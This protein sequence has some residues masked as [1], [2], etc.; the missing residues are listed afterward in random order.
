MASDC[1][2]EC[3]TFSIHQLAILGMEIHICVPKIDRNRMVFG[4][5]DMKIKLFEMAAVRHV[6]YSKIDVLVQVI[7]P[8]LPCD[9]TSAV[10]ISHKSAKMAP[11]YRRRNFL[12]GV[13][14][15]IFCQMAILGMEIRICLLNVIEIGWFAG[16]IWRS[17]Y[18]IIGAVRHVEFSKITAL[19]T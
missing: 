10:Q 16:E 3:K 11:W 15:P 5:W 2:L 1:H 13:R 18:L 8:V 7:S 17:S 4:V 14:L 9:S 12:Y 19:V 6:S